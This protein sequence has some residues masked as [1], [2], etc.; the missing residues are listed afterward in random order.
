[1]RHTN[2]HFHVEPQSG[3]QLPYQISKVIGEAITNAI[4]C[5]NIYRISRQ[6]NEMLVILK[7]EKKNVGYT[8]NS[9]K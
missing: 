8:K 1:M 6:L 2:L 7:S 3:L 5:A 9:R 4:V